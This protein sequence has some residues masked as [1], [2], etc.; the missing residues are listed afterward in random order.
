MKCPHCTKPVS[1][2]SMHDTYATGGDKQ[3]HGVAWVCPE[4]DKIISI[5]NLPLSQHEIAEEVI[6]RSGQS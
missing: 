4:C 5:T 2:F 6:R 1:S 3:L